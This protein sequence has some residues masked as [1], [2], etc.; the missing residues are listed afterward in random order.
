VERPPTL[1][2]REAFHR[3][4]QVCTATVEGASWVRKQDSLDHDDAQ[5]V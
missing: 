5:Q 1:R 3:A 2:Q 4:M